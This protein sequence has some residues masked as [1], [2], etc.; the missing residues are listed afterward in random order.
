MK[1]YL[2]MGLLALMMALSLTS[3]REKSE[4]EKLIDE[5]E[6]SGAEV[7][8]KHDGDESKIKM[9]TEDKKVKIKED[10][11]DQKIKIK[12]DNDDA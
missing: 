5:M 4:K 10:D 11:G 9:E 8:E 12:T 3:C 1:T 2:K 6:A 7:K